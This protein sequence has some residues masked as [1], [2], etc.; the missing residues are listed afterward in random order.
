MS[1]PS[2]SYFFSP[3]SV[4]DLFFLLGS[5]K[6]FSRGTSNP[7]FV[8]LKCFTSNMFTLF[9]DWSELPNNGTADDWSDVLLCPGLTLFMTEPSLIGMKVPF[10]CYYS[11][12]A[13]MSLIPSTGLN[14]S[15]RY[16]PSARSP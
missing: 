2:Y 13:F 12:K 11:V 9:Y 15:L 5:E 6:K 16:L 3:G 1:E 8:S 10:L 14:V 4:D 7:L